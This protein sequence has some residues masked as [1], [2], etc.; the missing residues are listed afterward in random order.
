[1]IEGAVSRCTNLLKTFRSG[2][3]LRNKYVYLNLW[4]NKESR[5]EMIVFLIFKDFLA[6]FGYLKNSCKIS[7]SPL[8]KKK[9]KKTLTLSLQE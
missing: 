1:M 4:N 3:N 6:D 2:G 8:K 9:K 7:L 5:I